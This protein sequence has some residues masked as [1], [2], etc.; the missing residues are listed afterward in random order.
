MKTGADTPSQAEFGEL[1]AFLAQQGFTQ[2]WIQS[3]T[4]ITKT[5][6]EIVDDLRAAMKVL[7]K[8]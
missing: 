2:Q 5:R 3:H 1:R 6:A 4:D 7:P 8:G